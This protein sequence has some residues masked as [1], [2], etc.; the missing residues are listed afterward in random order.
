MH[1]TTEKIS[2]APKDSAPHKWNAF[3]EVSERGPPKIA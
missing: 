3:F 1:K 2:T